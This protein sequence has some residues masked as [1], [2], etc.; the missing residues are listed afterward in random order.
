MVGPCGLEPQTSA[1]SKRCDYVL[2]ITLKAVK[3]ILRRVNTAKTESSQVKLQ[4]KKFAGYSPPQQLCHNHRPLYAIA[5]GAENRGARVSAEG[6][7][8][9][10]GQSK[11]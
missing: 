3:V 11:N 10:P 4:V 2:P 6:D 8:G 5:D 1:V 9:S 7:S